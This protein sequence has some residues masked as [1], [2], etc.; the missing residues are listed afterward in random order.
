MSVKVTEILSMSGEP[1]VLL[2]QGRVMY[3][4]D[5]ALRLFGGDCVGA[6]AEELIGPELSRFPARAFLAGF[7]IKGAS[8]IL[9]TNRLEEGRLVFFQ[10]QQ[11]T[12]LIVNDAFLFNLRSNLMTLG[13]AAD[14]L[15]PTV[16]DTQHR[17]LREDL[18]ALTAGYFKL[19][20]LSENAA[21]VHSLL[22][23]SPVMLP[24]T[25]DLSLLCQAALDTVEESFPG[26]KLVREIPA[27]VQVA[28]DPRLI[29]Q[30]LFNLLSNCFRHA[31]AALIQVKLTETPGSVVLAV[32]DNG[33]GI[34]TKALPTV[35]ERYRRDYTLGELSGGAGLGLTAALGIT[36][37]HGGT[38][39]L[40]SREGQGTSVRASFSRRTA[41]VRLGVS[42]ELCT[43][44]D[45]LVGLAD[46][47]PL[48]A[49]DVKYMD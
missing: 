8:Y 13:V 5:G 37:L 32:S 23:R 21:F 22:S 47:L 1:A 35:F 6:S 27:G 17:E 41:P 45:T 48:E 20:R 25:L 18:T 26:L 28:A 34:P 46:C 15:R 49:F 10:K 42:Q 39:L 11:E 12:P 24:V 30:L 33:V 16:E 36:R 4:N 19:M 31:Q 43:V 9:R 40:E 29:R 7:E 2:Q 38:L 3:A 14:K 44:R